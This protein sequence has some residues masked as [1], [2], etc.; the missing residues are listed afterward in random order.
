MT[1]EK[2]HIQN[3][4]GEKL[5][6]AERHAL[7]KEALR[8]PFLREALEGGES[9]GADTFAHDINELKLRLKTQKRASWFTPLRVAAGIVLVGAAGMYIWMQDD[10]PVQNALT[11]NEAKQGKDQSAVADTSKADQSKNEQLLS[12]NQAETTKPTEAAKPTST[13]T[14][15]QRQ[16]TP[17]ADR[18]GEV[19]TGPVEV[20]AAEARE[21]VEKAVPLAE[22][23]AEKI[24]AA[25]AEESKK[26]VDVAS[27]RSALRKKEAAPSEA[28]AVADAKPVSRTIRGQVKTE[29]G[30]PLPGVNV[31]LKDSQS[32][33]ITDLN[34]NYSLDVSQPNPRLIFSYLGYQ[35]SEVN[36]Q[37]QEKLDLA[38]AE[39]PTQLNEVV[40]ISE[41]PA[42][43]NQD[44]PVIRMAEPFGGRKAYDAYL[45][46]NLRYPEQAL[47]Q[48]VKGRVTIEFTV[49]T[50]GSLGGFRVLRSL[51]HGCDEEVIRLV[52]EGPKWFPTTEDDVAVESNVRVRMKFDPAKAVR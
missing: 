51:G 47:E 44:G 45:E 36:L 35:T 23:D 49:A 21:E 34:G 42:R 29:D 30:Q 5:T 38:L 9:V 7:E 6:S 4:L 24:T 40:V 3:Y 32:G 17:S 50:D 48:K 33:T 1:D 15:S 31:W 52:K 8:D 13:E 12:L 14:A 43:D 28:G 10:D 2:D 20:V 11:S 16:A 19:T 27:T 39:D 46:K 26:L 22:D 37:Q 25:E 41:R 18:A